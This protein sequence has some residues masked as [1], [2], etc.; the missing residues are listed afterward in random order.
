MQTLWK[1]VWNFL[2]KELK[3]EIPLDPVIPLAIYPKKMK[4]V[5]KKDTCTLMFTGTFITIVNTCKV[6]IH[7]SMIKEMW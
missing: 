2:K 7:R 3:I 6:S 4:T 1:T 5:I